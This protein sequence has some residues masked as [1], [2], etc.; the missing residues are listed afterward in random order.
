MAEKELLENRFK[1]KKNV[2]ISGYVS[3][4]PNEKFDKIII[5][6]LPAKIS[7]YQEMLMQYK[8]IKKIYIFTMH[9]FEYDMYNKLKMQLASL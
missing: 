5:F 2:T 1:N 7:R 4:M 3:N 6:T 8:S 9:K